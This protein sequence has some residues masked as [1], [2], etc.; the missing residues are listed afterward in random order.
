MDAKKYCGAGVGVDVWMWERGDHPGTWNLE[1]ACSRG[2]G[3]IPLW[4]GRAGV[5]L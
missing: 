2:P 5:G 1:P 3:Q 4:L